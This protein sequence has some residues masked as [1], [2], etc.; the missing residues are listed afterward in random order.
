MI[1]NAADK[2]MIPKSADFS[3]KI[4]RPDKRPETFTPALSTEIRRLALAG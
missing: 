2:S 4:M 1:P 3:A